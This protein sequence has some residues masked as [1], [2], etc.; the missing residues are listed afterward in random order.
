MNLPNRGA[1]RVWRGARGW[2]GWA[3]IAIAAVAAPSLVTYFGSGS[4][5]S[6]LPALRERMITREALLAILESPAKSRITLV[7]VRS[8]SE[9]MAVRIP[10]S[11]NVPLNE[12]GDRAGEFDRSETI[13]LYCATQV[14]SSRAWKILNRLGFEN[15]FVLQG[16]ME[17]WIDMRGPVETPRILPW[18][19]GKG[20]ES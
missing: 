5:L 1:G 2:R 17:Q 9:N 16:G 6:A 12:L 18:Q 13:V 3:L 15:V 11:R 10:A 8:K 14:R 19:I 7:D 4:G 20:C